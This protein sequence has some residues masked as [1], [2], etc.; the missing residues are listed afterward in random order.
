MLI[1]VMFV[2]IV[3]LTGSLTAADGV[4]DGVVVNATQGRPMSSGTDVALRARVDGEFVVVAT[5]TTQPD[6]SF[7]FQGLPLDDQTLYLPGANLEDVHFPGPRI[8]LCTDRPHVTVTLDV[9][10]SVSNSNPLV[11]ENHEIVIHGEPGSLKVRETMRINNPSLQ[12]YVGRPRHTG[13]GPVTLQLGIPE[14]FERITFDKEAFGRQFKLINDQLVTGIPWPPGKRELGFSYVIANEKGNRTWQRHVDLPCLRLVIKI[15]TNTPEHIACNLPATA[16]D[17]DGEARFESGAEPLPVG[18]MLRLE[19]DH[20]PR[21]MMTHARRVAS[22]L[23]IALVA[24][25]SVVSVR[26]RVLR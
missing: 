24:G 2:G 22:L 8:R 20:L 4:I 21:S 23:L 13:G 3:L 9:F 1:R 14:D 11:I 7:R 12:C 25:V 6:G 17:Q 16:A 15:R 19:L 18:H 10:D 5:T 26:Q